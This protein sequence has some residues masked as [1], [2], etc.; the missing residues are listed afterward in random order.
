MKKAHPKTVKSE[1]DDE[2]GPKDKSM[3]LPPLPL[4]LKKG[5]GVMAHYKNPEVGQWNF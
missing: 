1:K 2:A 5:P 3:S 4:P